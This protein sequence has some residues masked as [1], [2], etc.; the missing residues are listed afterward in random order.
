MNNVEPRQ[1]FGVRG[2]L[3]WMAV[4]AL[5]FALIDSMDQAIFFRMVGILVLAIQLGL[6]A[7]YYR[8]WSRSFS[9]SIDSPLSLTVLAILV[10][11]AFWSVLPAI[12]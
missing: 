5:S 2:F 1:S 11:L 4:L 12:H 3:G 6:T 8:G 9:P 7:Y 10:I